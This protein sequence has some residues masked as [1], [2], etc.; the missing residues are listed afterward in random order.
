MVIT[1]TKPPKVKHSYSKSS[2]T[3]TTTFFLPIF[4]K[5]L[6]TREMIREASAASTAKA[7]THA[8]KIFQVAAACATSPS[9]QPAT[10]AVKA[11]MPLR[12]GAAKKNKTAPTA[13]TATVLTM[14]FP[15][16][17]F[18]LLLLNFFAMFNSSFDLETKFFLL[19]YN[20]FRI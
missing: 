15:M 8:A 18:P 14:N 3:S 11:L 1:T 10:I 7:T 20:T 9:I 2:S 17:T 6:L 16:P 19:Y 12:I 5:S 4:P 13:T